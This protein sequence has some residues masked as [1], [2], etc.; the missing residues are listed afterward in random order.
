MVEG[1]DT[2]VMEAMRPYVNV[3]PLLGDEGINLNTAPP[4]VLS[5]VYHGSGGNMRMAD[6]DPVREIMKARSDGFIVCDKSET[7]PECRTLSEVGLGE[8]SI[9]P[10]V[11]LPSA[12]PVF[13]IRSEATVSNLTRSIE[14]VID[15]TDQQDPKLLSW[16]TL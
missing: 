16:H 1:F 13:T 3:H 14:A 11:T 15:L 10:P 6:E 8:G 12:T 9:F 4:H 5:L 2:Q 7:A